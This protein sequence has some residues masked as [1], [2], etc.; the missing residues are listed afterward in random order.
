MDREPHVTP[1]AAGP[2]PL[3]VENVR[4]AF[5]GN[6]VLIDVS[7]RFERGF[8]GLI[9]PNGA[10]KTT[11][12]NVV[13]G[14][15]KADRGGVRLFGEPLQ[16]KRQ[17]AVAARGV[18]RTFQSPRLVL[19][20][21]V[22]DNVLLGMTQQ[23]R[24][25]HFAELFGLPAARREE[26]ER[27]EHAR[28]LLDRFGLSSWADEPAGNLSL[29]SQKIV[30]VARALAGEPRLLLL[31]EPAAG[32]S[33]TDVEVLLQGLRYSMELEQDL[34]VI[35]IEHDLQLVMTLCPRVGVL[36]FGKIIAFGS[37]AEISRNEIVVEAYLGSNVAAEG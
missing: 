29:G 16:E 24:T 10:G 11:I 5:G 31:D 3:E 37:P 12:F 1:S 25:G 32:L 18:G 23:Y 2:P 13:S 27:R 8:N 14:Y 22:L 7:I 17:A 20:E 36:H 34:S 9:G 4:V 28:E 15:V 6:V 33:A 19:D 30:E 26:R 35:I 21:S